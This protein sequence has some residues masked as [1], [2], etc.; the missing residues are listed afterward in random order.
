MTR[1]RHGIF[2]WVASATVLTLAL[3]DD[4]HRQ[5]SEKVTERQ[6]D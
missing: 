3:A 6:S 2:S 1:S 4:L 5:G